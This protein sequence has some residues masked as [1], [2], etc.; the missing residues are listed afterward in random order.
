MKREGGGKG[1][2][3]HGQ[4]D[5]MEGGQVRQIRLGMLKDSVNIYY[6]TLNIANELAEEGA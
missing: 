6:D 1:V 5:Q 4:S 2:H 3:G